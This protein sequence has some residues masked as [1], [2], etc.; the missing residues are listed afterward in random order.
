MN[1]SLFK[2]FLALFR[3]IRDTINHDGI[4]HAGYLSF[5]AILSFFPSL[6]FLITVLGWL[7][8]L[9]IGND[10]LYNLLKNLPAEMS[11]GL[12]PRID[13]ILSGPSGEYLTIAFISI[14]WT[15]S[16]AVE[17]LRTI[18]NK[19]YNIKF[20]PP[21]LWR[22]FLSIIEFFTIIFIII[23]AIVVLIVAPNIFRLISAKM[24][25]PI[26]IDYDFFYLR[27]LAMI[28]ILIISTTMLYYILPS[29]KQNLKKTLPGA[30]LATI[31]WIIASKCFAYYL[32]HYG[33]INFIYGSI[34]NI[35]ISMIFFYIVSF[36]F[37]LGA[38]FNNNYSNI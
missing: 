28:I 30:V 15:A 26:V 33:Q 4:E 21:Y 22:R 17:G 38:E 6:I 19:A 20:P 1:N 3:G 9:K 2:P 14:I 25:I 16:S 36:I 10:F 34:A 8:E 32:H 27:Q 31:L 11:T 7:G 12:K 13:E 5:L 37:I 35:I 24:T 23:T 29:T 18:L